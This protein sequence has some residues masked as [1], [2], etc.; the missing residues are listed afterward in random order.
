MNQKQVATRPV[1]R[2]KNDSTEMSVRASTAE[3]ANR[4]VTDL[5]NAGMQVSSF[6]FGRPQLCA[7]C[8]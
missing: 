5:S 7:K 4:V 6:S 1:D 2:L 8:L 3:T